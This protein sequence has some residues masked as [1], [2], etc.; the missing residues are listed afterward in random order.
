MTIFSFT[1]LIAF[2][3]AIT[4][5]QTSL[6]RP[7]VEAKSGGFSIELIHPSSKRSPASLSIELVP[8]FL[9]NY[10]INFSVGTPPK[11]Q[12]AVAGSTFMNWIQCEPCVQC[13]SQHLPI[14]NSLKSS[15]YKALPCASPKCFQD[16]CEGS[17]CTYVAEYVDQSYSYGDLAVEMFTFYSPQGVE[18]ISF[19]DIVFGCAHRSKLET[20]APKV[21]GIISLTNSPQSLI[22]QIIPSFGKIFSYCFVPLAQLDVPSTLT[23]GENAWGSTGSLFTPMLVKELDPSYFL[24]L[25]GISIGGKRIDFFGNSS[26]IFREGNIKI[27]SGTAMT[28]LPTS[29][30]SQI[31]TTFIQAIDAEP[32][33]YENSIS[34]CYKDLTVVPSV[35]MHFIAVDLPLSKDNIMFPKGEGI[36]CLAFRPTEGQPLYGNVAQ[37][38]F[39]VGYDLNKMTISFKATDCTKLA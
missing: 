29:F 13:Y 15:T 6:L 1:L 31:K 24:T 37:T 17:H 9:G 19:P 38:N 11:F 32:L 22:S 10:L 26:N 5:T 8:D 28:V 21:S 20:T 33:V 30:Y 34:L 16:N 3:L 18:E 27:D 23:F 14:F 4:L 35:T 36:W 39:L 2:S 12:L 25:V 7:E